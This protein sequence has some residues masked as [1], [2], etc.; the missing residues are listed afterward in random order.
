MS[1][2]KP[3]LFAGKVLHRRINPVRHSL[4]Y[5]AFS[6]LVD[7]DNIAGAFSDSRLFSHNRWNVLAIY[8]RDHGDGATPDLAWFVRD[9]VRQ[10][11]GIGVQRVYMF[12]FPRVFG[13]VFNPL[14]V[15]FCL[16]RAG[17]L[18]A[19][20]YEVNNTFGGRTHY[21][22]RARVSAGHLKIENATKQLLVSPFNKTRGRYGFRLDFDDERLV[23]GVSLKETGKPVLNTSYASSRNEPTD[24]NIVRLV[25]AIP[26]MTLKVVAAIHLEAL[27]LWIKGLR[28][29]RPLRQALGN[30]HDRQCEHG[31]IAP[32]TSVR[33]A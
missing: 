28:P 27:K 11:L 33:K 3:A 32:E 29:P 4:R 30:G 9:L 2:P 23:L 16:D 31:S 10:R 13:Y 22:C 15:Y 24:I 18:T 20:V 25:S 17:E 6:V 12:A 8:D 1:F 5:R 7:L 26:L 19:V 14:T 21:A